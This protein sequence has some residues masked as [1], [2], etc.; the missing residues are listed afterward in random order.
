[1]GWGVGLGEGEE[2]RGWAI[3]IQD[4]ASQRDP[5]QRS[6]RSTR[7]TQEEGTVLASSS[8]WSYIKVMPYGSGRHH[9]GYVFAVCLVFVL[10]RLSHLPPHI[11]LAL[12]LPL[13]RAP[14]RAAQLQRTFG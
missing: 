14:S 10:A 13:V 9:I 12:F 6:D 7:Y 5:H 8:K 4:Y 11:M 3:T 1:M 2:P